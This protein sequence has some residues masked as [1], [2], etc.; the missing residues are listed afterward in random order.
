VLGED[1]YAVRGILFDKHADANW[2]VPFH[3]DLTIAVK[4]R[5]DTADYGPWTMKAGVQHV[6]PPTDILRNML[7]VRIHLDDSSDEN[8]P[9]RVLPRTHH[10]RTSEEQTEFARST[11]HPVTCTV[12]AGGVILM[13]PLLIHGSHSCVAPSR[14][15]VIHIEYAAVEL[16]HGLEWHHRVPLS[17]MQPERRAVL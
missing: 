13:R 11:C 5:C 4:R 15:R 9:L 3:Q 1:A 2:K 6:Q 16:A 14:R 10:R 7:A 8:G 12:Q 17:S